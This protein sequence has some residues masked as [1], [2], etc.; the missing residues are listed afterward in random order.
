MSS[1][2]APRLKLLLD[3]VFPLT[4]RNSLDPS[5]TSAH[6]SRSWACIG[7]RMKRFLRSQHKA[8]QL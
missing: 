7:P 6:T 2:S 4:A 5:D 8:A 3:Q 1:A